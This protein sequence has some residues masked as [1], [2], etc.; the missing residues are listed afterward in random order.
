MLMLGLYSRMAS[1]TARRT[2]LF[3]SSASCS[4][5]QPMAHQAQALHTW[6]DLADDAT[7][8]AAGTRSSLPLAIDT[9]RLHGITNGS[10]DHSLGESN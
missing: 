1:S 9:P 2:L 6:G 4:G 3:V 8:A 5:F 10:L 7:C